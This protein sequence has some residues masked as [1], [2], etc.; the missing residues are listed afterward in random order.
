M[1]VARLY[2]VL[3]EMMAERRANA[4]AINCFELRNMRVPHPCF[5]MVHLRDEGIPAACESDVSALLT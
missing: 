3:S 2:A 1:D 4:M 5:P